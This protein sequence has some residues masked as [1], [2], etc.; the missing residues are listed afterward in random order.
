[1]SVKLKIKITKDIVLS[2][3]RCHG[4][5]CAFANAVRDILPDAWISEIAITPFHFSATLRDSSKF[6]LTEEMS[7]FIYWFDQATLEEKEAFT[8]KEF[9]LEIPDWVIDKID[10]ESI[11]SLLQ[12]HPVLTLC[13]T[14]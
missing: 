10:I 6:A 9:E 13:E 12:N 14:N 8:E 1:M 11:R 7:G 4:S 5:R 3:Q 2:S